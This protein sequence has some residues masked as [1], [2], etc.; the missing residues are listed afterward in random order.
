M[1]GREK[2]ASKLLM[3]KTMSLSIENP[4]DWESKHQVLVLVL[5]LTS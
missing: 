2:A 1:S 3:N 4:V 5:T